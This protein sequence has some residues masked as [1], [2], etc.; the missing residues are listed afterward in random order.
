[1][2]TSFMDFLERVL[3]SRNQGHKSWTLPELATHEVQKVSFVPLAIILDSCPGFGG[4]RWRGS[5]FVA[6]IKSPLPKS[7]ALVPAT[8][9]FSTLLGTLYLFGAPQP[10]S[11]MHAR[12]LSNSIVP[13]LSDYST[14]RLYVYSEGDEIVEY[15][16]VEAHIR[17]L[18]EALDADQRRRSEFR[19]FIGSSNPIMVEK[20]GLDSPHVMHARTDPARYW[21]AIETL[22]K[23]AVKRPLAKAKL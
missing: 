16:D 20:F 7:V 10:F 22:W 5:A 18:G 15:R 11:T 3:V 13:G 19:G 4:I 23:E 2:F 14:P 9:A 17:Y 6:S 1:M 8:I 12:L 21:T